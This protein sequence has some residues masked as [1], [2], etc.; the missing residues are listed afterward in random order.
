VLG[1][2]IVYN[3]SLIQFNVL[4]KRKRVRLGFYSPK[5]IKGVFKLSQ[6]I[7]YEEF[8]GLSLDE[9][10]GWYCPPARWSISKSALVL[11]PEAGTDYWGQTHYGFSADNGPFLN[12][13]VAG[14]FI[15][16]T[17]VN[18]HP[19]NQYD[20]AGLMVRLDA[21]HWIKTCVEHELH[22]PSWLG[23]VVTNYGYSDWSTQP[24]AGKSNRVELRI[25]KKGLD[26]VV[27]YLAGQ[28]G[29]DW[30]QLRIAHLFNPD[31]KPVKAGLFACSPKGQGF[32]AEFD[33]LSLERA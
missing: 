9:R 32:K 13:E 29:K 16:A 6:Q 21:D 7:L 1:L 15:L 27:Q 14:D 25:T 8:K 33:Y 22:S 2:P 26:F 11:E 23:V 31:Q 4:E 3:R 12:L 20:Q 18:F 10:L 17:R 5:I 24:F 19:V 28:T 30:L